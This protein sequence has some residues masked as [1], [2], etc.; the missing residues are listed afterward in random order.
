MLSA[1][2]A[3]HHRLSESLVRNACQIC[4][5]VARTSTWISGSVLSE[6]NNEQAFVYSILAIP[7]SF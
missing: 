6:S 7:P 1:D 2:T 4:C 5:N 3:L